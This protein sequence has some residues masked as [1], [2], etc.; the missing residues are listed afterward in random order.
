MLKEGVRGLALPKD[1]GSLAWWDQESCSGGGRCSRKACGGWGFPTA[2]ARHPE[3]TGSPAQAVVGAQG[4]PAGGSSSRRR[5]LTSFGGRGV[6]PRRMVV[7][8]ERPWGVAVLNG[9]GSPA[10]GEGASWQT[11]VGAQGG[12]AGDSSSQT[13]QAHQPVERGSLAQAR[14]GARGRPAGG[15]CLQRFGLTNLGGRS[16]LSRRWSLLK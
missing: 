12:P 13:T 16:V 3:G 10:C 15:I 5:R 8:M 1:P 9:P 4:G 11:E 7:L 6:L 2:R 14:V